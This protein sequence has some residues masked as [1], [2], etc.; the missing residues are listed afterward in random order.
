M[1]AICEHYDQNSKAFDIIY[2]TL[3]KGPN[4][5]SYK[6]ARVRQFYLFYC[7]S[8]YAFIERCKQN[9]PHNLKLL[10]KYLNKFFIDNFGKAIEDDKPCDENSITEYYDVMRFDERIPVDYNESV[11]D[12]YWDNITKNYEGD[13]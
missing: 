8:A 6:Q 7:E 10:R 4:K 13:Q 5:K 12:G 9:Q 3:I 2:N 11:A 1:I